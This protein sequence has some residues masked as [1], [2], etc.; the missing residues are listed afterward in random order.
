MIAT[1]AIQH[2][3]DIFLSMIKILQLLFIFFTTSETPE[4][5][6]SVLKKKTKTYLRATTNGKILNG[7]TLVSII[8]KD[9]LNHNNEKKTNC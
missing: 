6:F 3:T 9:D 5:I 2:C 4:C 7:W 1:E 8:N